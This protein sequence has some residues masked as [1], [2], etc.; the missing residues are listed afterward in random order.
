MAQLFYGAG[1][2]GFYFYPRV[3]FYYSLMKAH[4]KLILSLRFVE[5]DE[6]DNV[7]TIEITIDD[8]IASYHTQG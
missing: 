5:D 8:M 7:S 4:L 3:W 1:E 2:L 6:D